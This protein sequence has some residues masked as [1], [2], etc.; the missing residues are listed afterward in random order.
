MTA[1]LYRVTVTQI[2]GS[3][4]LVHQT[5]TWVAAT[6]PGQAKKKALAE[7]YIQVGPEGIHVRVR[8]YK[9]G[10]QRIKCTQLRPQP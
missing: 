6:T 1:K 9:G 2:W 7:A 5:D 3:S 4:E 8:N 10:I